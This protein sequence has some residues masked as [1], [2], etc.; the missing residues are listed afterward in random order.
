MRAPD[1]G[2]TLQ[3]LGRKTS[4]IP[5]SEV[6]H[7]NSPPEWYPGPSF[8]LSIGQ[9]DSFKPAG[10]FQ[11]ISHNPRERRLPLVDSTADKGL[12]FHTILTNVGMRLQ[13]IGATV[14]GCSWL[15]TALIKHRALRN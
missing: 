6:P 11:Q 10:F 2:R 3:P 1:Q 7:R 13:H 12:N 15:K 14:P 8:P 5:E 9:N 4:T